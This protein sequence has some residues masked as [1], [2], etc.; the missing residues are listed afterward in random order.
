MEG[1]VEWNRK[2]LQEV[3]NKIISLK[4]WI[5]VH[6]AN[7]VL[8]QDAVVE[9]LNELHGKCV[10]IPIDQAAN[11]IAIICK[12]SY[13]TVILKEIGIL[14][15]GN[16]TFEKIVKNQEEI[17]QEHFKYNT[18]LK[19]SNGSKDRGLPIMYWVHKLHKNPIGSRFI[20]S[21]KNCSMKP[22]PK[23]VSDVFKLIYSQIEI[24]IV[25]LN[26]FLII[27]NSGYFTM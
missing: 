15:V 13:V 7:A 16:K 3:D 4:H 27:K 20:A 25:N 10:L 21:S 19:L 8:K 18:R 5:K 2:I 9:Y 11:N 6:K 17:I 12:K 23:A 22:L 14:D 1:F 24:S 26:S